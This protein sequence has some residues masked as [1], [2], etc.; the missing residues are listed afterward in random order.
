RQLITE[1]T[2]LS[3]CGAVPGVLLAQIL[4]RSLAA[5]A[6]LSLPLLSGLRIDF[7]ALAFTVSIAAGTGIIAGAIP[8]W[9]IL[10]FSLHQALN[11]ISRAA[12]SS[13]SHNWLRS[14]LVIAEV[15]LAFV[16]L[17]GAG[18]FMRS[19]VRLLDVDL[20]FRPARVAALRVDAKQGF[21][22]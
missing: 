2:V 21:D 17:T 8:A 6:N 3:L 14:G 13:R 11:E 20:G 16:L 15:A 12:T 18:L 7:A 1:S 19:F 9:C 22:V 10:R 4:M 5:S